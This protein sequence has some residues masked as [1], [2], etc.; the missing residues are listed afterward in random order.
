MASPFKTFVSFGNAGHS[1]TAI[2]DATT[3]FLSYALRS[4]TTARSDK[5]LGEI[6]LDVKRPGKREGTVR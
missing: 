4:G 1:G 3:K 2:F 5:A 6:I